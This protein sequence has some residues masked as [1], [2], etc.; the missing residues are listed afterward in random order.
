MTSIAPALPAGATGSAQPT[1]A[2]PAAVALGQNEANAAAKLQL[3]EAVAASS[4]IAAAP[5]Q[6]QPAVRPV[7]RRTLPASASPLAAQLLAQQTELA[8][9]EQ[10]AFTPPLP[11]AVDAPQQQAQAL[12]ES[13]RR[14]NQAAASASA[15]GP[16]PEPS[17]AANRSPVNTAAKLH[18]TQP[19]LSELP[20]VSAGV[21]P[22][23]ERKPSLTTARGEAAYRVATARNARLPRPSVPSD[24]EAN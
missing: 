2:T 15:N 10:A 17:L 24:A 6:Q 3:P 9:A 21:L 8:D 20:I 18:L 13:L 23:L 22:P 4:A 16:A 12:V 14:G 19:L 1:A 5:A 7:L 11:T